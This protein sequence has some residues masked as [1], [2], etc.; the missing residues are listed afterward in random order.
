MIVNSMNVP[1]CIQMTVQTSAVCC[2]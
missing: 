1:A 2:N